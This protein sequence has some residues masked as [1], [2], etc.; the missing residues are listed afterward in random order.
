[1][2]LLFQ[3]KMTLIWTWPII[4]DAGY[5]LTSENKKGPKQQEVLADML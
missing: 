2:F 1:M 5:F 4:S 3:P